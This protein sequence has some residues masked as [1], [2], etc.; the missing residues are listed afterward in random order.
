MCFLY[1][2]FPC[3]VHLTKAM[4]TCTWVLTICRKKTGWGDHWITVRIFQNQHINWL[5]WHLPFAIRFLVIVSG[6]WET[7]NWKMKQMAMKFPPL[8]SERKK[9]TTSGDSLHFPTRF[10]GKLLFHLTFN[11]NFWIFFLLNGKHLTYQFLLL[12]LYTLNT[13]DVYKVNTFSL[14]SLS[15]RERT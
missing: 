5:R 11:Q 12:I 9:R 14:T 4:S 1:E 15:F 7:K 3:L 2:T 10:S 6:W 8:R 13:S